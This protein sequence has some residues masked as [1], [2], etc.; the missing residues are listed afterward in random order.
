MTTQETYAQ[1]IE[2][3][4]GGGDKSWHDMLAL[5]NSLAAMVEKQREALKMYEKATEAQ[6]YD[7]GGE[8]E[9]YYHDIGHIA[10]K[11]LTDCDLNKGM[12]GKD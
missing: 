3:L 7:N 2:W 10:R 5:I 6:E 8:W 4:N 12:Y 11:A 9:I 1:A